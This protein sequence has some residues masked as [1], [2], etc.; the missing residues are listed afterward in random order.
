MWSS[1][2]QPS[3]TQRGF[4]QCSHMQCFFKSCFHL[5]VR[6]FELHFPQVHATAHQ[7]MGNYTNSCFAFGLGAW[8][9]W[10]LWGWAVTYSE[11]L[12][13]VPKAIKSPCPL[14]VLLLHVVRWCVHH[15]LWCIALLGSDV[16][17]APAAP[18]PREVP[19]RCLRPLS[20]LLQVRTWLCSACSA[21]SASRRR[22]PC[23]S[24]WRCTQG[25]AATSAASATAPSPATPP[26][27]GTCA[28]TQVLLAALP[29]AVLVSSGSVPQHRVGVRV[30][31]VSK[32]T[33]FGSLYPKAAV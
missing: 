27:R 9:C 4:A 19:G 21:A 31:P 1:C 3:G 29:R 26:S 24:T 22:R 28:P 32:E 13:P 6:S 11:G 5:A 12:P 8:C 33:L 16:N 25:C 14:L 20:P 7:N 23:S 10:K 17:G 2:I 18:L 30:L 15:Q